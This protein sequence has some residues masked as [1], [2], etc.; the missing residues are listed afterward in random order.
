MPCTLALQFLI[1]NDSLHLTT[2]MRSNDL[3]FGFT[4]DQAIFTL[5]QEKMLLEL[6]E[7]YPTL[8]MGTY[9]HV[10]TSLHAYEKHFE[11]LNNIL[12]FP[13]RAKRIKMPRM[14]NTSDISSLVKN[15]EILRNA[16]S[17]QLL[18]MDDPLCL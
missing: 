6:K 17:N 12:K 16:K 1:R 18:N 10:V 9:T 13:D 15:E 8:E 7:F 2:Y 4:Y 11:L 14:V 5:F 3:L